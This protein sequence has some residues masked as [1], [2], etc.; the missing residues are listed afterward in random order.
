[1]RGP[2][3]DPRPDAK[4]FLEPS[5]QAPTVRRQ[6]RIGPGSREQQ[7]KKRR[8]P[9]PPLQ[10]SM[11][12]KELDDFVFHRPTKQTSYR[13]PKIA[14]PTKPGNSRKQFRLIQPE[15]PGSRSHKRPSKAK[16]EVGKSAVV[17]HSRSP[18]HSPLRTLT[19][20]CPK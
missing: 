6:S 8:P 4:F 7:P 14:N 1:M 3:H 20:P 11:K 16:A 13:H 18:A 17:H 5:R 10:V 15:N 9:L 19:I 2:A 12:T